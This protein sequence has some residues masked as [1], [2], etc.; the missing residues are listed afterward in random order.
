V[1]DIAE[2]RITGFLEFV[3]LPLFKKLEDRTFRKMDL[4]PSSGEGEGD[5]YSVGSLGKS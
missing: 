4:F 5:T 1:N 2:L 3:H